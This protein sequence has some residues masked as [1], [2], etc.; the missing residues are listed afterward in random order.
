MSAAAAPS[1]TYG[2]L[3]FQGERV[4]HG[5]H[6]SALGPVPVACAVIASPVHEEKKCSHRPL[7]DLARLTASRGVACLRFDYRYTGDSSG[8]PSRLSLSSM[9]ADLGLAIDR[10]RALS[11]LHKVDLVGLRL[12]ADVAA[13]VTECHEFVD[14]LV[15]A[16]PVISGARYLSQ[17]RVRSRI[18]GAMTYGDARGPRDELAGTF[19]FDGHPISAD[20]QRE[21]QAHDLLRRASPF[22]HKVMCLDITARGRP[23]QTISALAEQLE[24]R[25]ASVLLR[26]VAEV[27]FWNALEPTE[28]QAFS[29]AVCSFLLS[30]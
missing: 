14:R 10:A 27:P 24:R 15:L 19:D 28:T 30:R 23:T 25:G 17:A 6:E 8:E 29:E 20:A 18:R 1:E 22:G 7:V 4:F 26:T 9:A 13:I 3:P 21:L 5:F 2:F 11:G 12:G 16:A